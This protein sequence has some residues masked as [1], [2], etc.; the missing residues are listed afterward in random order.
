MP[1][2][3]VTNP[4]NL[5]GHNKPNGLLEQIK[6]Y[7]ILG[8]NLQIIGERRSGKTSLLK[9]C[10]HNLSAKSKNLIPIYINYR[11]YPLI[12]GVS[13][14][15]RLLLAHLYSHSQI[16]MLLRHLIKNLNID[17]KS[18]ASI[19]Y[20]YSMFANLPDQEITNYV[21][22]FVNSVADSGYGI[23]LLI[24]EYEHLM[25]NTFEGKEGAFFLLRDLSSKAPSHKNKSKPLTY[26]IAGALTWDKLC[27]M[28]GSPELNNTGGIFYIEPLEYGD[29]KKMWEKC[30]SKTST[31]II[32]VINK[33]PVDTKEAFELSG[34]WPF[35]GKVIGEHLSVGI[36]NYDM[37]YDSLIQ[38]FSV[39]WSRLSNTE[40]EILRDLAQNKT[41]DYEDNYNSNRNLIRRGILENNQKT[42]SIRGRFW[43]KYVLENLNIIRRNIYPNNK[44]YDDENLRLLVDDIAVTITEINETS[45][46][47]TKK[48]IFRCSNQDVQIYLDL[49]TPANNENQFTH[50]ALSLYNLIFERTTNTNE[51]N[52]R[53][54][55]LERLPKDFRYKRTIVRVV[56]SI[57]HHFGKA[58]I[59]RLDT[60]NQ[61]GGGMPI[62]EVL[63]LYLESTAKPENNQYLLLQKKILQDIANY[64]NQLHEKI[65]K[66][67][68]PNSSSQPKRTNENF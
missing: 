23:I 57:R 33:S 13:N 12:K 41:I 36:Y 2:I 55:P 20:Y 62:S 10:A 64:L 63:I 59:T 29:F 25:R 43:E 54:R 15:Y 9:C 5:F 44:K 67:Q 48:E 53:V 30:K 6:T 35:F 24:D 68:L 61:S 49:A 14:G 46:N 56:D 16:R 11:E 26:I 8:T 65:K 21:N 32:E 18:S 7:L 38:H 4:A 19:E 60:F 45:L 42:I 17:E 66:V 27:E 37:I 31:D 58:H 22:T 3:E 51:I 52:G 40:K 47:A 34:G 50:F 1:S 28:T 39:I